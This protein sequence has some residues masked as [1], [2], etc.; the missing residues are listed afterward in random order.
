MKTYLLRY[1]VVA[2]VMVLIVLGATRVVAG[3]GR[4]G[5][6]SNLS[7]LGVLLGGGD[8][9]PENE[10]LQGTETG[11]PPE[12]ETAEPEETETEQPQQTQTLQPAG[13]PQPSGTPDVDDE[14]GELEGIVEQISATSWVVAGHS[15]LIT[16]QTE[17]EGN[18]AIGDFVEVEFFVDEQGNLTAIEIEAEDD[19]DDD[20]DDN[21]GHGGEDDDEDH[22][23]DEDDDD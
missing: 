14:D 9:A 19:E 8:Q 17:I 23:D 4:Q 16:G 12:T 5:A 13:T 10:A 15:F 21:E 22:D 11:Q 6:P 18:I 2:L 1:A 7:R 20:D 3:P